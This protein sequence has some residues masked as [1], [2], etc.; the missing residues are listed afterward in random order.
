MAIIW[1]VT[2]QV[3]HL[4]VSDSATADMQTCCLCKCGV[5]WELFKNCHNSLRKYGCVVHQLFCFWT[6]QPCAS[7]FFSPSGLEY[8]ILYTVSHSSSQSKL[9]TQWIHV[10]DHVYMHAYRNFQFWIGT[11]MPSVQVQLIMGTEAVC[12]Q[13]WFKHTSTI[14]ND[15]YKKPIQQATLKIINHQLSVV[16]CNCIR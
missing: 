3:E 1:W 11:Y 16:Y 12:K 8:F 5:P 14:L 4:R 6:I 7:V 9:G 13:H 2:K 10:H 15:N